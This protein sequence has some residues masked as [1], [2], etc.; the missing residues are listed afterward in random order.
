MKALLVYPQSDGLTA[1]FVRLMTESLDGKVETRLANQRKNAMQ[2]VKEWH[3]DI[4]HIFG[5]DE[6]GKLPCRRVI[7]PFGHPFQEKNYTVVL[8]RSDMEAERLKAEGANRIEIVLNPLITKTTDFEETAKRM[9]AI[10]W[11]VMD[12]DPLALMTEEE[13]NLL[14]SSLKVAISGDRRWLT[15]PFQSPESVNFRR[16]FTYASLEGILSLVQRGLTLLGISFPNYEH[17]DTYLPENFLRPT[18][19]G[20]KTL[21]ELLQDIEQNGPNLLRLT[22]IHLYLLNPCIDEDYLCRQLEEKALKPLFTS[23]LQL[24]TEQTLL[25]EGFCP[26]QPSDNRLTQRLRTQLINHLQL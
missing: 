15:T 2:I 3:P 5:N 19:M 9:R 11:K 21:S 13:R 12:S 23:V 14:S 22:E 17:V 25:D 6:L 26:C 1:R 18:S 7:S 20:S 8:A 24:L 16:L 4:V 10:Y